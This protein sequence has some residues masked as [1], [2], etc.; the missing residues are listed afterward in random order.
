MKQQFIFWLV[1]GGGA[2]LLVSRIA[3]S[4]PKPEP[5]GNRGYLFLYNFAQTFLAN[6]D[7]KVQ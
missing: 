6:P 1:T 2:S 4:L 7:Q 5:L 3:R